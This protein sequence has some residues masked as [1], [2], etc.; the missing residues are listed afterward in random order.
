[1]TTRK[2]HTSEELVEALEFD[3]VD[4]TLSSVERPEG[5]RS[6]Q[7]SRFA[8]PETVTIHRKGPWSP[9]WLLD[10]LGIVAIGALC[11]VGG[12]LLGRALGDARARYGDLPAAL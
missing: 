5:S 3:L 10:E 1:M 12:V 2:D 4:V 9:V 7:R 6:R 8:A 11:L